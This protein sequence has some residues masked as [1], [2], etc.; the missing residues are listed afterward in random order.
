ME[1]EP[2]A[3]IKTKFP[4]KF[5]IPRQG[6]VSLGTDGMIVFT[7]KYK[8]QDA[9]KGLEK[10]SHIWLIWEFSKVDED[11]VSSMTV[12]P[13]KLGGNKRVGV[14]ATRS[15]F[16]PNRLGLTSVKLEKVDFFDKSLGPVLYI[17]GADM[18][19]DTPIIDIKPYIPYADC[20]TDAVGGFTDDIAYKKLNVTT[21]EEIIKN[22]PEK[23][24]N[25]LKSILSEDPRPSYQSDPNRVYGMFYDDL[26]IK[27][28]VNGD[29]ILIT[30]ISKNPTP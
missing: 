30:E 27:F 23:T 15:P 11:K 18:V 5:G 2:I 7:D 20:H 16:R 12:R 9:I 26:S 10:F 3:Y 14:F 24:L 13:P 19:T 1:V 6:G 25:E 29:E 4:E 22:I 8:N 28:K 17:S 21:D